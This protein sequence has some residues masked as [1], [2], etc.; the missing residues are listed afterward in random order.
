MG[1]LFMGDLMYFHCG[2][3]HKYHCYSQTLVKIA[4]PP[5]PV[6]NLSDI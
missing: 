1:I 3:N 2:S 4:K 6:V 5:T